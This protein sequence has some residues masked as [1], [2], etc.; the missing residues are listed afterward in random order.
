MPRLEE[1]FAAAGARADV[2]V[3][4]CDT[5]ADAIRAAA[6]GGAERIAIG[7]G[8]GTQSCAAG[9]LAGLEDAPALAVLPLGTLNHLARDLGVPA[10]LAGAA[11]LAVTGS[12]RAI[13]IAS[14]NDRSFINN[15]SIGL[16][17]Q[18]VAEREAV[19]ERH[20][21]PKWLATIPAAGA[22]LRRLPHHRLRLRLDGDERRAATPLL[23]VGNNGYRLDAGRLGTRGSLSDGTL[24]V[25][26]VT[27][28]S[29][30]R[31]LWFAIRALAGRAD[32]ERDFDALGECATLVVNGRG[33]RVRVGIDGE[34]EH[35]AFPL[36]FAIRPG[37]LRVVAPPQDEAR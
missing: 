20:G 24:S 26:A 12:V 15:A 11:R 30:T 18:M 7:G 27:R 2:R 36:R 21:I 29:R 16:Y 17:P 13:D 32:P 1:A 6:R 22:T 10:D 31:L 25:Y 3:L 5:L 35:M 19:R 4:G 8:D 33:G 28:R 9:V 14:L 23:F 34:V 37:A